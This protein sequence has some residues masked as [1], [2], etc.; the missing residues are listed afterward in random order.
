GAAKAVVQLWRVKDRLMVQVSDDGSGFDP[1]KKPSGLSGGLSG[2]QERAAL[3]GGRFLLET[4]PEAGTCITAELPG[5]SPPLP[6]NISM[7]GSGATHVAAI[8]STT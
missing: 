5:P 7:D 1:L 6:A 2:M 4:Q 8:S 3:L